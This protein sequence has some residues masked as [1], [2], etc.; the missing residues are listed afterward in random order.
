MPLGRFR[1]TLVV[2]LAYLL[3]DLWTGGNVLCEWSPR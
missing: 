3:Q 1:Q 2:N